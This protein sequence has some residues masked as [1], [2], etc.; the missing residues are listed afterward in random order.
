MAEHPVEK[1]DS[2][3]TS[4]LTSASELGVGDGAAVEKLFAGS[5][6]ALRILPWKSWKVGLANGLAAL[7]W[8]Q[9]DA[10]SSISYEGD[11]SVST[12]T[13]H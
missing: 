2:K 7:G 4:L 3:L 5:G 6:R 11:L 12:Q 13:L 1:T 9:A 10:S 8:E